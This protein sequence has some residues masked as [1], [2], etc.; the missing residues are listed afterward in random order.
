MS[1]QWRG[2]RGV[3]AALTAGLRMA[4]DALKEDAVAR[5]P[6]ASGEMDR[7]ARTA[8]EQLAGAVG[9]DTDYAIIQHQRRDLT[10]D[11]GGPGFLAAALEALPIEAIVG[12]AL[13][14][15]IGG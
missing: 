6:T 15:T 4:L 12:D 1:V 9:F 5:S 7:S 11:D 8:V 3:D 2:A 10:H 13:K 14:R